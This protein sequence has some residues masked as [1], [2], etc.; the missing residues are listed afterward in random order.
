MGPGALGRPWGALGR[1][2]GK[3]RGVGGLPDPCPY[4]PI[5][6]PIDLLSL[7]AYWP[8]VVPLNLYGPV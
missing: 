8:I 1:G 3:V 6:A 2:F 5:A 7:L 4:W